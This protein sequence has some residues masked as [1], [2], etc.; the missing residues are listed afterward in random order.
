MSLQQ[1]VGSGLLRPL[2]KAGLAAAK[3]WPWPVPVKIAT[4]RAMYVDL[5]SPLGRGLYMKGEFDPNVFEPLRDVLRLGDTFLDVG[6]NVGY[7]SMLALD[8]VGP[9][10]DVHAF[11]V[12]DR[13]LHCLRKTKQA[14][15]LGNFTIH[16]VAVGDR[17]GTVRFHQDK[18]SGHS[19]LAQHGEGFAVPMTT[20]DDWCV[21]ANFSNIRA[22]KMDI[23]GAE[24]LALRGARRL[25]E[26]HRPVWICEAWDSDSVSSGGGT[27]AQF[28]EPLG[29]RIEQLRNVHS[30]VVV[31]WPL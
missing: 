31:A 6:A 23:E 14:Y 30:P 29:Y 24:I 8:V 28:L 5:R 2:R 26:K 19:R 12:D 7:Y 11:E 15:R 27:V 10:G 9:S 25:I 1:S 18:D 20:L 4:G 17:T 3:H 13:P 16:A 21:Q 22:I